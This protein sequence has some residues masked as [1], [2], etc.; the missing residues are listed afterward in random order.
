MKLYS[1]PPASTAV[2][3]VRLVVWCKACEHR[4]RARSGRGGRAARRRDDGAGV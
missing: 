1:G 4:G 3:K 2:V